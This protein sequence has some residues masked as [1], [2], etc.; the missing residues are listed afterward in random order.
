MNIAHPCLLFD[1]RLANFGLPL[2]SNEEKNGHEFHNIGA[3]GDYEPW[4]EQLVEKHR[5]PVPDQAAFRIDFPTWLAKLSQR[6]RKVVKQLA[7]GDRTNDVARSFAL[8]AGHVSQLRRK[9]QRS[10]LGFHGEGVDTT[11]A[12]DLNAVN[13]ALESLNERI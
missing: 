7:S 1:I 12:V 6:D 10:W 3:A 13:R 5:T 2:D 11:K 4:K 9:L 8:S